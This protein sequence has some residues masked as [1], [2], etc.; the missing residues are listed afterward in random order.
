MS[1]PR[2]DFA[3]PV[4]GE[5]VPAGARA[6]PA[7]GACEKSG[8][9][10]AGH[11]LPEAVEDFDYAQFVAD[12][13]GRGPRPRGPRKIWALAALLVLAALLLPLLRGCAG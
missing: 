6:C 2:G 13:F 7:C 1:R 4:C 5:E 9:S 12:E 8:W 11:E 10:G 3:C